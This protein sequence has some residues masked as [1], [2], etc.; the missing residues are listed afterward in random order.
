M[1]GIIIYLTPEKSKGAVMVIRPTE[2]FG[3]D[4]KKVIDGTN[5]GINYGIKYL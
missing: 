4:W 1:K 5:N 2:S 3:G